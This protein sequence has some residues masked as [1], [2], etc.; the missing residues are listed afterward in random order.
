MGT[1]LSFLKAG[2]EIRALS[3]LMTLGWFSVSQPASKPRPIRAR[4]EP[5][6]VRLS[7]RFP[8]PDQSHQ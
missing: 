5:V 8:P 4:A 3:R 6:S 7:T 1:V 2:L